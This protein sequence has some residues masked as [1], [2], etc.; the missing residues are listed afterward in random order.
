MFHEVFDKIL[1]KSEE[2]SIVKRA[3]FRYNKIW[4][5]FY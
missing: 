3:A 5:V 4:Y 2:K 1:E